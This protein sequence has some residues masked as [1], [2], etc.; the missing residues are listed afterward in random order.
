MLDKCFEAALLSHNLDK[1]IVKFL[2]TFSFCVCLFSTSV[3]M[4]KKYICLL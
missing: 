4:Y 2:T 3:R 1:F